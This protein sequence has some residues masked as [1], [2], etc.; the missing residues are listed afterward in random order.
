MPTLI[1]VVCPIC[2]ARHSFLPEHEGS[3]AVCGTCGE[4]MVVNPPEPEFVNPVH[5]ATT[6]A[7]SN[8]AA[9]PKILE[10]G[11]GWQVVARALRC[12]RFA[13]LVWLVLIPL[14]IP[15]VLIGTLLPTGQEPGG[16]RDGGVDSALY[17]IGLFAV[18]FSILLCVYGFALFLGRLLCLTVPAGAESR[19]LA[20]L[21]FIA[22]LV[23]PVL[24]GAGIFPL[25]EGMTHPGIRG[26]FLVFLGSA[27]WLG[28]VTASMVADVLFLAFMYRMN[29]FMGV[30]DIGPRMQRLAVMLVVSFI[31]TLVEMFFPTNHAP[32]QQFNDPVQ[33]YLTLVVVLNCLVSFLFGLEYRGALGAGIAAIDA[34]RSPR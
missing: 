23:T 12:L 9:P 4:R 30:A 34:A 31:L 18:V 7:G 10:L 8:K 25:I 32:A 2:A 17:V 27:L 6:Q 11:P 3:V 1:E 14:V 21:S 19:S 24:F 20:A 33:L 29:R 13:Y 28:G 15:F 26:N 16:R 5:A 22:T